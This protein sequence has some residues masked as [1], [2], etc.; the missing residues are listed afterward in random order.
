MVNLKSLGKDGMPG[1]E[2]DNADTEFNFELSALPTVLQS[3]SDVKSR[4]VGK[5]DLS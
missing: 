3:P 2:G 1:G 4:R 5:M